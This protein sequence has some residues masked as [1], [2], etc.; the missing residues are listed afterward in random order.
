M[1]SIYY[2]VKIDPVV[3]EKKMLTDN[4]RR[5]TTYGNPLAISHLREVIFESCNELH[6]TWKWQIE[7][8]CVWVCVCVYIYI[9]RERERDWPQT[10]SC[11]T[12]NTLENIDTTLLRKRTI[13]WYDRVLRP[14][15]NSS[16]IQRRWHSI[17]SC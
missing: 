2:L 17:N 14:F 3:L 6:S 11:M 9:K 1:I 5:T 15:G 12:S 8:V 4:A 13:D 16:A 7:G 10:Y